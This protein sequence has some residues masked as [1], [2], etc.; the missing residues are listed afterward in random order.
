MV[1]DLPA[2]IQGTDA[3]AELNNQ[4][5][6]SLSDVNAIRPAT[7]ISER[8]FAELIADGSPEEIKARLQRMSPEMRK[9]ALAVLER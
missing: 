3:N 1:T 5:L 2:A 8:E 4:S 6:A 9:I 7:G